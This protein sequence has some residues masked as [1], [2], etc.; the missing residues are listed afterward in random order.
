MLAQPMILSV[1]TM[2]IEIIQMMPFINISKTKG[3]KFRNI[4]FY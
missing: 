1:E 3:Y 2:N 4:K